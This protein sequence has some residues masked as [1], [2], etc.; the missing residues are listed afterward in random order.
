M[1]FI[2]LYN[3]HLQAIQ[4][5][6]FRAPHKKRYLKKQTNKVNNL[7]PWRSF[8]NFYPHC[9][10]CCGGSVAEMGGGNLPTLLFSINSHSKPDAG[11]FYFPGLQGIK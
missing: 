8:I 5:S 7:L 3:K 1:Y 6:C 4:S 2:L 11:M 10:G 9:H